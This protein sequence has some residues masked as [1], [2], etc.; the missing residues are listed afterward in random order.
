MKERG[1]LFFAPMVRALL[2]GT[3]TQTRRALTCQPTATPTA[4]RVF[5]DKAGTK[6]VIAALWDAPEGADCACLCAY[7][8]PGDRLW[9]KE[10]WSLPGGRLRYRAD[11]EKA[12]GDVWAWA[13]SIHMRRTDSRITLE[14]TGVR[15]ERVQDIS[16][17]D[18]IAEGVAAD[19]A[20]RGDDDLAVHQI[21]R[22][23][24]AAAGRIGA[25]PMPVARYALLWDS[26]N[27]KYPNNWNANPW[28]W[29]VE[30]RRVA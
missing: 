4:V 6:P 9:V 5:R 1:I 19:P 13:P 22:E 24:D 17:A 16:E 15:I 30:F 2:A 7:G 14:V 20:L 23:H 25:M 8:V 18:A 21:A 3:K 28:A 10:T 29:V 12:N 26:I 27:G 11:G